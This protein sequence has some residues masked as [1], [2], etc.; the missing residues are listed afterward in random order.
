MGQAVVDVV[1]DQDALC[2][3]HRAFYCR[4]LAGN[5]ET[6]L[7]LFDHPDDVSKMTF[8]T[9]EPLHKVGV[10]GMFVRHF[11]VAIVSPLGGYGKVASPP[12]S[13]ILGRRQSVPG[14]AKKI[15]PPRRDDVT[16][17]A[18]CDQFAIDA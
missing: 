11:H 1:V 4:E 2:C 17:A 6:G 5:V 9:F 7:T 18:R 3:R 12:L 15:A 8:G 16:N 14:A 10:C 13:W